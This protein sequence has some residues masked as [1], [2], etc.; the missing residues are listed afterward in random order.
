VIDQ[1]QQRD[2]AE[3]QWQR[4]EAEREGLAELIEERRATGCQYDTGLC[5][6]PGPGFSFCLG[7]AR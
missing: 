4:D 6:C 5:L 3:E 7:K 2:H 1:D